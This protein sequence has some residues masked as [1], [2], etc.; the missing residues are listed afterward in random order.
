MKQ[1]VCGDRLWATLYGYQQQDTILFKQEGHPD[2]TADEVVQ[3]PQEEVIDIDLN[4]P[5]VEKAAV[6]IQA[7]FKGYHTRKEMQ[8]HKEHEHVRGSLWELLR[9]ISPVTECLRCDRV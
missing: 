1:E 5:E 4:D 7:S 6:K 3:Q 9:F 2:Q 8:E